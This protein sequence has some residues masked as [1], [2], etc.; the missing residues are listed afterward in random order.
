M[1]RK[2][3]EHFVVSSMNKFLLPF[4]CTI[5]FATTFLALLVLSAVLWLSSST[6]Y[7]AVDTD[8]DFGAYVSFQ[9]LILP[10]PDLSDVG[11][12]LYKFHNVL[13]VL[14]KIRMCRFENRQ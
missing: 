2:V 12:N 8:A 3:L 11:K 5:L 1:I 6:V 4:F 14:M 9:L 7:S 10:S 13:F